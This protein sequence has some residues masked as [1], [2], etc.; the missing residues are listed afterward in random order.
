[1]AMAIRISTNIPNVS[2]VLSKFP[3]KMEESA[4]DIGEAW[5]KWVTKRAKKNLG[6]VRFTGKLKAS[7]K[8]IQK[9]RKVWEVQITGGEK[10]MRYGTHVEKGFSP[11]VIPLDYI[12]QHM[13]NPGAKGTWVSKPKGFFV[14]KPKHTGFLSKALVVSKKQLPRITRLATDKNLRR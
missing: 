5:A 8:P 3:R 10:V 13:S 11:H 14:S 9:S 4:E 7:I 12:D 6:P 2:G 1:M